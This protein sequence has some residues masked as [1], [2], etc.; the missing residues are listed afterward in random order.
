MNLGSLSEN[1]IAETKTAAMTAI[2]IT[3]T[4]LLLPL[5]SAILRTM[6]ADAQKATVLQ[7]PVDQLD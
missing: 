2:T 5:V 1:M 4:A 7:E 3:V 6:T